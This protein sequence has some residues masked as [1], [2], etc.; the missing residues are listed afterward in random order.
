MGVGIVSHE[1]ID[2]DNI[3]QA[4]FRAMR[5]AIDDL[6]S[7]PD[8]IL[9]DGP[10][11]PPG[12]SPCR[13]IVGGDGLSPVIGCASI[14]AKVLRDRLMSF[15]HDL[16]PAYA[17]NRHK[18]YGTRLHAQRLSQFGPSFLHRSS[19][20]PVRDTLLRRGELP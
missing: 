12:V 5:Q 2:Q 13:P 8:L 6:P 19:F 14:V 16:Y 10:M 17:F 1:A 4:T 15:Y 3:L 20:K 9:V 7:S 11:A 18:G